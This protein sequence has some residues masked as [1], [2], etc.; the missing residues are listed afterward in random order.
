MKYICVCSFTDVSHST[1]HWERM[2]DGEPVVRSHFN[3]PCALH[4]CL[5]GYNF[6]SFEK[7]TPEQI[8][9]ICCSYSTKTPDGCGNY[10][11]FSLKQEL[12]KR[13]DQSTET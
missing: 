7:R 3:Y 2:D 4:F 10:H 5:G 13:K 8:L 6:G 9:I 1:L 11:H 12:G